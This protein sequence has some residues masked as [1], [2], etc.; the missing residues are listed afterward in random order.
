MNY[1]NAT[2]FIVSGKCNKVWSICW[3]Q[4]I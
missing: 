2:G 4:S 3:S 1:E